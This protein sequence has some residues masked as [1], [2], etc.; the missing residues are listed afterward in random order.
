[1]FK[2]LKGYCNSAD[3]AVRLTNGH[4]LVEIIRNDNMDI[5]GY[6]QN[7]PISDSSYMA[8]FEDILSIIFNK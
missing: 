8:I 1:M 3:A 4:I 6:W 5:E 7:D 2:S